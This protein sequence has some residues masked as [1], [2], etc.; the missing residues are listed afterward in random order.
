MESRRRVARFL[1]ALADIRS[2]K[3]LTQEQLDTIRHLN[4]DRIERQP[5]EIH[6]LHQ[7][8]EQL[9]WLQRGF[10][11]RSS[12]EEALA[13]F[14]WKLLKKEDG[15]EITEGGFGK[16]R[17]A[18]RE[19]ED[20]LPLESRHLS[21]VKSQGLEHYDVVWSEVEILRGCVHENIVGFYGM[22]AVESEQRSG[23]R[24]NS[25]TAVSDALLHPHAKYK[26]KELWLMLEYANAG[27]LRK[28]VLRYKKPGKSD[29]PFIPESGALYYMKQICAGVQHLHEK[30]IVHRDLHSGNILLKYKMDGTKICM[31]CDFGLAKILPP[32]GETI[33]A[34]GRVDLKRL[35]VIAQSMLNAYG[36]ISREAI[37]VVDSDRKNRLP[38][39]IAE[40]LSFPWFSMRAIP[41]IPKKP[42]PILAPHIVE[43]MGYLPPL[44]PAGTPASSSTPKPGLTE[45]P[46]SRAH[47]R[48]S[49]PVSRYRSIEVQPEEQSEQAGGPS[50]QQDAPERRRT[51]LGERLRQRMSSASQVVTRP[52]RRSRHQD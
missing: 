35:V 23:R 30:N 16:I 25:V 29:L 51:S 33:A 52:F 49:P 50:R 11:T 13:E 40:F 5:R 44:N 41:P 39:T 14:K 21:F 10:V 31:V 7:K 6:Y 20:Q 3:P 2:T 36:R 45:T 19:T 47:D 48:P 37:E 43:Q 46:S 27:D 12:P 9:R 34:A 17:I 38:Q 42:T 15:P 22:F 18:F 28:E 4:A 26:A 8:D 1:S 32:D 24:P